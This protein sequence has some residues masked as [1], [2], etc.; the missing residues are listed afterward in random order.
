MTVKE[1]RSARVL[2][3]SPTRR[4]LLMKFRFPW[5]EGDVWITP[6]GGLEPGETA[7][8]AAVRELFE[9]TGLTLPR[10]GPEL[11]TREHPLSW[12][13][14]TVLLCERYF[15]AEVAEFEP[16]AV[17]LPGDEGVWFR[18]FRWC[19]VDEI[20]DESL[21]FAPRRLGAFVRALLREG[22]PATPRVIP[23]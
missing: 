20:P 14:R 8:A 6:G 9:E 17:D 1:R 23:I 5:H 3:L 2:V 13:G 11:W 7:E 10:V 12:S 16:R 18:G 15:L 4:V 19:P 22:P 21:E